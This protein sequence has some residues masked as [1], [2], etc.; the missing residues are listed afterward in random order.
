MKRFGRL[1]GRGLP[2]PSSEPGT[3]APSITTHP[4]STIH[5]P[6]A[7][8]RPC[9]PPPPLSPSAPQSSLHRL[10]RAIWLPAVR[11][12]WLY[13]VDPPTLTNARGLCSGASL[14]AQP[15]FPSPFFWNQTFSRTP[16]PALLSAPSPHTNSSSF[17]F[18]LF[19]SS[20][21]YHHH[22]QPVHNRES[23]GLTRRSHH[24]Q[25]RQSYSALHFLVVIQQTLPTQPSS[26]LAALPLLE[27]RPPNKRSLD[28]S[29]IRQSFTPPKPKPSKSW[30]YFRPADILVV[31]QGP[32]MVDPLQNTFSMLYSITRW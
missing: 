19:P 3:R 27:S 32:L 18:R 24:H 26:P 12:L 8:C 29:C 9:G 13:S 4:P 11:Q 30:T 6:R 20:S 1:V 14:L 21:S 5:H 17:L 7:P 23:P 2:G 28:C 31:L 25:P 15:I 16:A 22:F 10:P